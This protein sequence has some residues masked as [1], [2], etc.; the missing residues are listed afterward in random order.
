MKFYYSIWYRCN[1]F[2]CNFCANCK[3]NKAI[4]C[5]MYEEFTTFF[6]LWSRSF[7]CCQM[8]FYNLVN[9]NIWWTAVITFSKQWYLLTFYAIAIFITDKVSLVCLSKIQFFKWFD[10]A[11]ESIFFGMIHCCKIHDKWTVEGFDLTIWKGYIVKSQVI[12]HSWHETP[13]K[14]SQIRKQGWSFHFRSRHEPLSQNQC[15]PQLRL[16]IHN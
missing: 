16:V 7:Y 15:H 14:I 2:S 13:A 6:I 1:S 8:H 11:E 5:K 4:E 12:S 3:N 9:D 10:L